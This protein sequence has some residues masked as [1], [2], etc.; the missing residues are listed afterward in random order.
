M[1]T[2]P[3]VL[4][5]ALLLVMGLALALELR[6]FRADLDSTIL[7]MVSANFFGLAFMLYPTLDTIHMMICALLI[8]SIE[9]GIMQVIIRGRIFGFDCRK[10]RIYRRCKGGIWILSG[11]YKQWYQA[12]K[13]GYI[14]TGPPH[15]AG[16]HYTYNGNI[17]VEI[18]DVVVK[19]VQ[20]GVKAEP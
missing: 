7:Y 13:D 8:T 19:E 3:L 14:Y 6:D 15:N 18:Y 5:G 11:D 10:L 2:L 17:A 20:D 12:N 9:L 16:F 4:F 1:N